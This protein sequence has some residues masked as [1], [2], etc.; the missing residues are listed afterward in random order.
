MHEPDIE[1]VTDHRTTSKRFHKHQQIN[2]YFLNLG[3]N[4]VIY[5]PI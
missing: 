1:D 2:D 4:R 3:P 5:I